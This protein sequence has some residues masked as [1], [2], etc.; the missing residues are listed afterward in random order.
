[1]KLMER[2]V[3]SMDTEELEVALAAY[4]ALPEHLMHRVRHPW[5]GY[6]PPEGTR[7]R[8]RE[9][10]APELV[11]EGTDSETVGCYLQIDA[12]EVS[13]EENDWSADENG[14]SIDPAI[15]Y[16]LRTHDGWPVRI[17]IAEGSDK[18]VALR[19]LKKAF[20]KLELDWDELTDAKL[21]LRPPKDPDQADEPYDDFS[22]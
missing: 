16:D 3:E 5:V 18:E 15:V 8:L 2:A 10:H 20:D 17:Q 6:P 9:E 14:H 11:G 4:E 12:R 19:L 13:H 22:W 21:Y 7:Q 1:M